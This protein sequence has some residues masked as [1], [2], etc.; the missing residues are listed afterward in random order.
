MSHSIN[1]RR[2]KKGL[3]RLESDLGDT[4]RL[5]DPDF[6]NPEFVGKL[7]FWI[8]Y[9]V[10]WLLRNTDLPEKFWCDGSIWERDQHI[11]E[12]SRLS[13]FEFSLKCKLDIQDDSSTFDGHLDATFESDPRFIKF[14]EYKVKMAVL[15]NDYEFY[16]P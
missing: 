2:F 12:F 7:D 15:G 5:Y 11:L 1:K 14:T 10:T 8:S 16:S 4:L 3:R 6:L 9:Y 13:K